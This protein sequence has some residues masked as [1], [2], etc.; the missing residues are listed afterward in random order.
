MRGL[1]ASDELYRGVPRPLRFPAQRGEIAPRP[2]LIGGRR[3]L[4]RLPRKSLPRTGPAATIMARMKERT[5]VGILVFR[6]RRGSA[7]A[8]CRRPG[9]RRG[10][11]FHQLAAILGGRLPE[12]LANAHAPSVLSVLG[13]EEGAEY[14][15]EVPVPMRDGAHLSAN[16]ILPRSQAAQKLPVILIRTPYTP[17]AEVSEPLAPALL[18]R[19]VRSGYAIVIVNDRGT[20]WSEG[21]YQWLKGANQDG[22]DILD[23]ITQQPWSNGKVGTFGC[24]S[25]GESQPPL[26]TINHPAHRAM[27]EMAGGTAAGD[28]PGYHDQNIFYHG[29]V[30]D[31]AWCWWYAASDS[32]TVRSCPP[33]SARTRGCASP[34]AIRRSPGMARSISHRSQATCRRRRFCRRA[35]FLGRSGIASSVSR[36]RARNGRIMISCATATG[37]GC[38]DCTSTAGTTS[39]RPTRRSS[40]FSIFPATR[41]ISI[42]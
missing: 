1:S 13:L 10:R 38:P 2:A 15:P 20:Q 28:I 8:A 41:P 7:R 39:S 19:A 31:L 34:R 29:G 33:A 5:P 17:S 27:V 30:P 3:P 37:R 9:Q 24:S 26:A 6:A 14:R 36:L 42:W 23:W 40:C 35:A 21:H 22:S 32:K 25:S 4:L 16:L 12:K 11:H 18:A